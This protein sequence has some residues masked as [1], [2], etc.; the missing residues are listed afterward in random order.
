M[1]KKRLGKDITIAAKNITI[2]GTAADLTAHTFVISVR[3]FE[4]QMYLLPTSVDTGAQAILGVFEG[5]AQLENR[6]RL[7]EYVVSLWIDYGEDGQTVIDW[8]DV[9]TLVPVT[10]QETSSTNSDVTTSTIEVTG[11]ADGQTSID[12]ERVARIAADAVKID[13]TVSN[14]SIVASFKNVNGKELYA[15]TLP[16]AT[17]TKAG[18]MSASDK[19]VLDGSYTVATVDTTADDVKLS[20]TT[21]GGTEDVLTLSAA[22]KEK[23][24]VMSAG[25]EKALEGS[26]G[27]VG[28]STSADKVSIQLTKHDGTIVNTDI[29]SASSSQAGVMSAT[30]KSHLDASVKSVT[31][32]QLVGNVTLTTTN[33]VGGTS[34]VGLGSATQEKAGV[35]TATDKQN[36]DGS[37]SIAQVDTTADDVKLSLTTNDSTTDTLTIGAATTSSAGVMSATDKSNLD[38]LKKKADTVPTSLEVVAPERITKGNL[39]AQYVKA[40]ILPEECEQNIIY[41]TD[42]DS[43][44]M[45]PDGQI[46]VKGTGK[47]RIHVIPLEKTKLYKTVVVD[48]TEPWMRMTTAKAMRFDTSGNI[49]LI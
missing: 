41:Q 19:D 36:L 1:A 11:D 27:I 24:G 9:L 40:T 25:Q 42:G 39:A 22:T 32:K 33:N 21:N 35:M 29:A 13:S 5:K 47:T 20:L 3:D 17:F 34:T 48:V 14:D 30:D 31:P 7:G 43:I 15:M 10:T 38:A 26:F 18:L 2:G 4:G 37:Y 6:V 46:T 28:K 12:A 49:R 16:K 23:A 8:T 44:H 45:E